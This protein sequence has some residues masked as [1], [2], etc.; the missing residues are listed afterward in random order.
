[1]PGRGCLAAMRPRLLDAWIEGCRSPSQ[2]LQRHGTRNIGQPDEMLGI[3]ER[4]RSDGSH[5]LRAVQ[6][7][8]AFFGFE[9]KGSQAGIAQ[10]FAAAHAFSA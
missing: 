1:M 6:Q 5:P 2:C 7:R 9:P 3:V 4:Q 8:K 10:R